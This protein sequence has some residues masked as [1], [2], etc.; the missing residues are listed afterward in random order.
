M[1]KYLTLFALLLFVL[2]AQ[3]QE[4]HASA[5]GSMSDGEVVIDWTLGEV[6]IFTLPGEGISGTQGFQQL[7][8][9][10]QVIISDPCECDDE[11]NVFGSDGS[12]K[13]FHDIITI[14]DPNGNVLSDLYEIVQIN[15]GEVVSST[16]MPII[17]TGSAVS[18][19]NGNSQVIDIW[20]VLGPGYKVTLVNK[21]TGERV[22]FEADTDCIPCPQIP[23]LG[24]W[25]LFIFFLILSIL[26]IG[27]MVKSRFA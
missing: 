6:V 24:A 23:T 8:L 10:P 3:A 17:G 26:A 20:R 21:T 1:N 13:Y 7:S 5:G 19:P 25:A 22:F 16:G 11:L 18:R 2:R 14:S 27:T 4:V 9:V 12:V 15:E